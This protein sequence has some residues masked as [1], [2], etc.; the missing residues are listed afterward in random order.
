M[1]IV[2]FIRVRIRRSAE[3][4]PRGIRSWLRHHFANAEE[5]HSNGDDGQWQLPSYEG[6]NENV[7]REIVDLGYAP[8]TRSMTK[9]VCMGAELDFTFPYKNGNP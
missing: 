3:H 2:I 6:S 5:G 4:H 1:C 9:A 8:V 7:E